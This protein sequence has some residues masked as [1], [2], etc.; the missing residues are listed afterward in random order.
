MNK[1]FAVGSISLVLILPALGS[2]QAV[3]DFESEA[4]SETVRA[5]SMTEGGITA[6]FLDPGVDS[7][8]QQYNGPVSHAPASWGARHFDPAVFRP[9]HQIIDF[10]VPIKSLSIEF[11]DFGLGGTIE[12]DDIHLRAWSALGGTGA[13]LDADDQ[14]YPAGFGLPVNVGT[15]S[16]SSAAGFRSLELWE[17]G[18]SNNNDMTFDN[19]VV[20][21]VPETVSVAFS[22]CL[23]AAILCLIRR[24]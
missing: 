8:I 2:A 1:A 14:F 3:F 16:V 4:L 19:M 6:S 23:I 18:W 24:R 21:A 11:G 22:S 15:A 10:N 7:R 20:V 13:V 9:N 17:D 5:F 12:Y